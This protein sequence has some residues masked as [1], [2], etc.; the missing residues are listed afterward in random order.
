V[1][2]RGTSWETVSPRGLPRRFW[3]GARRTRQI[4]GCTH[5]RDLRAQA[6]AEDQFLRWGSFLS[7]ERFRRAERTGPGGQVSSSGR[8]CGSILCNLR[9]SFHGR[10]RRV[11]FH[12]NPGMLGHD[13]SARTGHDILRE[14]VAHLISLFPGSCYNLLSFETDEP[15]RTPR[16][17]FK[18]GEQETHRIR[19]SCVENVPGS[20]GKVYN[21]KRVHGTKDTGVPPCQSG[22]VSR[23][24]CQKTSRRRGAC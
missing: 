11:G 14:K 21:E 19:S 10:A 12:A 16:H 17:W 9:W 7:A 4:E 20:V 18:S 8:A 2:R 13:L 1:R 23:G 3:Q 15:T 5:N 6:P 22:A 24:T